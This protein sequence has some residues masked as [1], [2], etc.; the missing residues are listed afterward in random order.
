[1]PG[2][3]ECVGYSEYYDKEQGVKRKC[4]IVSMVH[5]YSWPNPDGG[6]RNRRRGEF[7][8]L[9]EPTQVLLTK[10]LNNKSTSPR[11]PTYQGV[12]IF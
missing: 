11:L 4:N 1:M 2:L 8:G 12:N 5:I 3:Q 9:S 6:G 10:S 7:V